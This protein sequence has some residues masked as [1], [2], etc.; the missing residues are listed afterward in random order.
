MVVAFAFLAE[1]A[2]AAAADMMEKLGEI[3]LLGR[4]VDDGESGES[5]LGYG[6]VLLLP[7]IPVGPCDSHTIWPPSGDFGELR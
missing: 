6:P 7:F 1:E 5:W 2:A 4:Q 3:G